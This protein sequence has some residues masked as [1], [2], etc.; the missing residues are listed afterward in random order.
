M[1]IK[2]VI[3]T[4]VVN[5]MTVY[6]P[7]GRVVEIKNRPCY[8]LSICVDGQITYVQNGVKHIEDKLHAVILPQGQSY[9]LNGDVTGSFPLINFLSLHPLG[10]TIKCIEIRNR[11][12]LLRCYEEIKKLYT[13][14]GSR[15][16]I[17]SLLYE[18][19]NELSSS[20][21]NSI[22]APA[23]NYIYNNYCLSN[24]TNDILAQQCNIS[25][26]YFRKLFT[27]EFGMPPKQ[28]ILNLRLKKAKQLLSEGEQKIWAVASSCGFENSAHF[29]RIFKE[30]FGLT[31]SE[32]RK[33]NEIHGI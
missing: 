32:Y 17:L 11:E 21:D 33:R 28:Y 22:L 29:C 10:D 23:T 5:V 24:I 12:F 13:S 4:D 25:E 20:P 16:K 3:I 14:E 7:K 31:P 1:D 8:G 30:R 18:M 2:N 19:I 27:S 6:S 15:A 26:V 9:R